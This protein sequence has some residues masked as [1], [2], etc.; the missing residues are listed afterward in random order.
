MSD[1]KAAISEGINIPSSADTLRMEIKIK[2]EEIR[3][4]FI[5]KFG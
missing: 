1:S 2:K 5:T 4:L 3:I